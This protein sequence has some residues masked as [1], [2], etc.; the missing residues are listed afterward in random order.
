MSR[1]MGII[2]EVET[3]LK[4]TNPGFFDMSL[5]D[6][7]Q[8]LL[9]LNESKVAVDASKTVSSADSEGD[10]ASLQQ[11]DD[12]DIVEE[13]IVLIDRDVLF[14]VDDGDQTGGNVSTPGELPTG[15]ALLSVSRTCVSNSTSGVPTVGLPPLESTPG[16]TSASGNTTSPTGTTPPVTEANISAVPS[17][18]DV[19]TGAPSSPLPPVL[20]TKRIRR[21]KQKPWQAATPTSAPPGSTMPPA[22][23]H[24]PKAIT[25]SVIRVEVRWAPKD[26]TELRSSVSKMHAR[27]API[28]SC[29]N[30]DN[31]WVM[32]W[33][34]DQMQDSAD[35]LPVGLSK[36]LS[37]RVLAVA[38]ERCFYFSF[39][40]H[41]TGSA[42]VKLCQS[43]VFKT[44]KH[45]ESVSFDPTHIPTSQGEITIVGDILLK[46][47]S[48]THRGQ[49]LTYLRKEVLPPG[50]VPIFYI[51]VRHKDPLGNKVQILSV[52]C[53]KAVSTE[54]AQPLS[55]A[56]CGEQNAPEILFP[57]WVWAQA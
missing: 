7:D 20:W 8:Y 15:T 23:T 38:K 16:P 56:L 21:K 47:A 32:E 12:I 22:S 2:G 25:S 29:F 42:F 3:S 13:E 5:A 43:P 44:T 39:R 46:D 6:M 19:R 49:Y 30:T 33:Q 45:G 51:K 35:I 36:Y 28:L 9:E 17:P 50:S 41:A 57:V 14:S 1:L 27:F 26:H 31:T 34:T 53:G 37:V 48:V 55:T 10:R 40:L 4:Q 54:V 52:R 24:R 11:K 18:S